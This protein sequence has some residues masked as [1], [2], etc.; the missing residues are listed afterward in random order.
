[1]GKLKTVQNG[2]GSSVRRPKDYKAFRENW[3]SINWGT[4]KPE[5]KWLTGLKKVLRLP[6]NKNLLCLFF[7]TLFSGCVTTQ[8]GSETRQV[9]LKIEAAKSLVSK[10]SSDNKEIRKLAK[11]VSSLLETG[12]NLQK[13]I[14]YKTEK[15]LKILRRK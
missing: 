8:S 4:T 1:M 10:A 5:N 9:R 13:R 15:A 11:D 12:D 14:D 6:M 7:V 3:D 2:K